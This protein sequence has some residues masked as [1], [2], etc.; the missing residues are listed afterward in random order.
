[1]L[2]TIVALFASCYLPLHVFNILK[3]NGTLYLWDDYVVIT[4]ALISRG[5]CYLNSALNPIIYNFMSG[6]FRQEF[7]AA[8]SRCHRPFQDSTK[9][10]V[11]MYNF[12]VTRTN[13]QTRSERYSM[14]TFTTTRPNWNNTN[15][16]KRSPV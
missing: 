14:N 7:R 9:T 13:G 5:M 2:M 1:M 12:R 16:S 8:F 3:F 10:P 6:K 15:S 11:R 4:Y